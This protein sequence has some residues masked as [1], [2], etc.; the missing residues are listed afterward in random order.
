MN[1]TQEEN[2]NDK[3]NVTTQAV[4]TAGP[5]EE[6]TPQPVEK[7][8]NEGDVDSEEQANQT[9]DLWIKKSLIINPHDI[10]KDKGIELYATIPS[11]STVESVRH[12]GSVV[13]CENIELYNSE[14]KMAINLFEPG[15]G[16]IPSM[17][18]IQNVGSFSN[19]LQ[20]YRIPLENSK[21]ERTYT[22]HTR[23]DKES[24]DCQGETLLTYLPD[25]GAL[26]VECYKNVN[27]CDSIVKSISVNNE[28][29]HLAKS[30]L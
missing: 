27:I 26:S 7:E 29:K 4:Q 2:Q 9:Q 30:W 11:D 18:E 23:Y 16:C 19:G 25:Y 22:Y 13:D 5:K 28:M 20:I 10:C 17:D 21:G 8:E 6:S 12:P 24:T 1:S 15:A 3:S 14:Y